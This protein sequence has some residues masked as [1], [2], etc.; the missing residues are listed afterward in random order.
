MAA[1]S[2]IVER[3]AVL[4]MFRRTTDT[5]DAI[6]RTW[7]EVEAAVGPLKGRKFYGAFTAA[8]GE[9]WVCVQLRADDD[10]GALE[11]ERGVLPG[12]RYARE[13]LVGYPPA[14]YGLIKPTFDRLAEH[15]SDQDGSR[16]SIEFYRRH[17]VIDLLLPIA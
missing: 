15:R 5:Q 8:T 16:P 12:G 7:A 4:V 11:L 17:D 3:E 2:V 10:P 14:V 1:G 6:A 9:Y 13:R